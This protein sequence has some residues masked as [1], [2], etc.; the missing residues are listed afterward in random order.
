MKIRNLA[1]LLVLVAA[2]M[3]YSTSAQT[4]QTSTEK[5]KTEAS[6]E[7]GRT[8]DISKISLREGTHEVYRQRAAG[9]AV[10][11]RDLAEQ[12]LTTDQHG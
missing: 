8:I 5:Q 12:N 10:I 4:A 1:A 6:S 7:K 2:S 9:I 11:A 3:T